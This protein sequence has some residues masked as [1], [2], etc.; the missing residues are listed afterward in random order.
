MDQGFPRFTVSDKAERS[1]RLGHPWVYDT[2]ILSGEGADGCLATVLNRKGRW[3]G[4]ALFNSRSKIR[5]RLIS[6][7]TNDD[8]SE[9]FFER[10]L[11]H[12]VEYRRTVMGPDFS[13]CRLIF[14]E[15]DFFPGLTV[16]RF[17]NILVAQT[18][19]LGM[20]QRKEM[21]FRLLV[22]ILREEGETIDALYERN[23]VRIR[24][25][26]G[27]E[28]GKGFF[29]MEGLA[30]DLS[31][32]TEICENGIRYEV[33]YING[34]KTGFFLDQK[35][36]RQAAARLAPG[37][38][39]L[40]C[41]T[42]TGA[43]ALNAAKA[44]AEHVCAVD[45]SADALTMA[46]KNAER[47]DLTGNMSFR[48]ANVFELLTAMGDAKSREYDYIILDPPAFTKSHGTV[49]SA[50]RGYHEINRRAMQI[51]PRGGYLATCSCS[52]F[53]TE[54]LFCKMLRHAASDAGR[55]LRQIEARQQ[56]PDHPI[57]WNVPETN[58]LKFYLFQVV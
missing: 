42:H 27:M 44:G 3:L 24:E 26:E 11:R 28:Q 30:K 19:S 32:V 46:R 35:Y 14:G 50:E 33:D 39:V 12:A 55:S 43:F 4:T 13:C 5:L 40:D 23:D 49:H 17:G 47:N 31:G 34:Q 22:K 1:I 38:R 21:L 2:E 37:R 6:R 52:H 58:Y 18:L 10:R 20:E 41:F 9:S 16:D 25:L 45:V 48:E 54:E 8:F 57:L 7:N 15:A 53:M 51:L 36:N 56:S 29:E